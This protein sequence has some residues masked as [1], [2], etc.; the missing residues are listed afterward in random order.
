MNKLYIIT[1]PTG[2]G[3]STISY[4]IGKKLEKISGNRR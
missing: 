1:G 4:E 3:K 2:V